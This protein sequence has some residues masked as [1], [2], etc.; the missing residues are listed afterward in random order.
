MRID[1]KI[2]QKSTTIVVVDPG[3]K[4]YTYTGWNY[5]AKKLEVDPQKLRQAWSDSDKDG[6]MDFQGYLVEKCVDN[7]IE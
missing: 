3:G 1:H 6:A 5:L 4:T 2:K 7:I